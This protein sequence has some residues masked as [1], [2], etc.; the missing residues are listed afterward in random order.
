MITH[1]EF[2]KDIDN[3]G[4]ERIRIKLTINKGKL[5][6]LVFQYESLINN[7]W[8]EIVRYDIS[9]GYFHRD[10]IYPNGEQEKTR[11]NIIDLK[12]AATYAEQD[13]EAKWKFYKY[14]YLNE[15]N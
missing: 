6:D 9:H 13:L 10:F 3:F 4:N 5:I 12:T 1:R 2:T 11:I 7:I 8:K 15:P 14:K